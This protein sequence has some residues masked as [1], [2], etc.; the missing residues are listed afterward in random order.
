MNKSMNK[1][2]EF[3]ITTI[4]CILLLFYFKNYLYYFTSIENLKIFYDEY[5]II[6]CNEILIPVIFAI[7]INKFYNL[8]FIISYFIGLLI[9]III[10]INI[11]PYPINIDN[12]LSVMNLIPKKYKPEIQFNLYDIEKKYFEYPIIIKPTICSSLGNDVT[13]IRTK[14]ELEIFL[15]THKNKKDYMV[16]NYLYDYPVEIGVLYEKLPF[17]KEGKII[18]IIEKTNINDEIRNYNNDKIKIHNNLINPELNKFFD[19]LSKNIPNMNVGRYDIRLK[20]INDLFND[21]FKILEIN[22]TVGGSY[23]STN[24]YKYQIINEII[25]SFLQLRWYF[26]RL[27]IGIFNILTF[28]GYS[29]ITLIKVIIKVIKNTHKCDDIGK[30]NYLYS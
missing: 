24:T 11:N 12:K 10:F 28:K 21:D 14:K 8:N 2:I 20:N 22:G 26:V 25:D 16:Q 3:I 6:I 4:I 18:E 15:K 1:K 29:L 7:I 17:Q 27:Y 19:R 9:K 23:Y 5:V 30:L 13:I